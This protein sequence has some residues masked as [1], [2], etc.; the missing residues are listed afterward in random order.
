MLQFLKIRNLALMDA[1]ELEFDGGFNVVTGETG[2]GKSV[3]LGALAIL[4]GNR[5]AKTVIRRGAESC[6]IEAVIVLENPGPANAA[7]EAHTLPLCED[8]QLILR[9]TIH[10]T[11]PGRIS[12]NGALATLAQLSEIGETWIDF[13]GPGEPQKLFHEK[14]QLEI[15]DLFAGHAPALEK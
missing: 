11:K 12:I 15:L 14:Y 3:L 2:A 5:V 10:A 1:V 9:R 6:E 13:H 8:G 7:L 4:A